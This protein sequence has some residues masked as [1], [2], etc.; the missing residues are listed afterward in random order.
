MMRLLKESCAKEPLIGGTSACLVISC[1]VSQLVGQGADLCSS[2]LH[3]SPEMVGTN[4]SVMR[5]FG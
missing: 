3:G 2:R 4:R 5:G 1:H